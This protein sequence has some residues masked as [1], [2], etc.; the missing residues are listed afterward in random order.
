MVTIPVSM[1]QTVVTNIAQLTEAQQQ[2]QLGH[3]LLQAV[4]AGTTGTM[5]V[6]GE[7]RCVGVNLVMYC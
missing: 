2:Q 5:Q 4:S 7:G 6:R 3:G 1:Y